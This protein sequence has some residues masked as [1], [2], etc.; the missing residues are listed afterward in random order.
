[1]SPEIT[2]L[3]YSPPDQV[4]T[5]VAPTWLTLYWQAGA[6]PP[7]YEVRLRLL[8]SSG[9]ERYRWAGQ[10]GYNNYPTGQWQPGQIVQDVWALQVGPDTPV[11]QY[12]LEISL[13]D[14]DRD[15]AISPTVTIEKLELWPQPISYDRSEMQAEVGT[16]FGDRLTL[17]GYD[18]YFDTDSAGGGKLS[19]TLYWQSQKDFEGSFDLIFTLRE[20]TSNEPV[21]SWQ[22]PLGSGQAKSFWKTGEVIN[23]IHQFEAGAL[24]GGRYHLDISVQDR[25]TGQFEPVNSG[26]AEN[27]VRIENLQ[28]KIVVRVEDQ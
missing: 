17:L 3:G 6:Q 19:P 18:L 21:K 10:P 16:A 4:L 2:L 27:A 28:D 20:A 23:T 24:V 15:Q 11:G 7:N 25:A 5:P 26:S 9:Q 13:L 12:S 22:I 8:D 1:M 14:L